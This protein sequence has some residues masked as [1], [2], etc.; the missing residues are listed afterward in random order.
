MQKRY[1]AYQLHEK[2]EKCLGGRI[3][4]NYKIPVSGSWLIS[5]DIKVIN[6]FPIGVKEL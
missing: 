2:L 1:V 4:F 6:K 5:N 3:C